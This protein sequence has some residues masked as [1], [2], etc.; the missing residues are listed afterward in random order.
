MRLD[1]IGRVSN[2]MI[3][4]RKPR[5]Y[6][7]AIPEIQRRVPDVLDSSHAKITTSPTTTQ[8]AMMTTHAQPVAVRCR[9][10]GSLTT[11]SDIGT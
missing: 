8:N 2:D 5:Q 11:A 10:W 9:S 7:P 3:H 6:L 4:L 1:V